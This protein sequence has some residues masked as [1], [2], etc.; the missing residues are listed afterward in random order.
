MVGG[1]FS[2]NSA[3]NITVLNN[4]GTQDISFNASP[5]FSGSIGGG[6]YVVKV[7]PDGKILMGG[8]FD[9]YNDNYSLGT[10]GRLLGTDYYT[11]RGNAK[12]DS[13][14]NGCGVSDI[15]YPFLQLKAVNSSTTSSFFS[16]SDGAYVCLLKNGSNVITPLLDNPSYFSV[17]P[18]SVTINYPQTVSPY[19]QDFCLTPTGNHPDVSIKVLPLRAA[20]PGFDAKYKLIYKN[21]GNQITNGTVTLIFNDAVADLVSANPPVSSQS[22]GTLSWNY[23]NLLPFQEREI[24]LTLQLNSPTQTPPLNT[25]DVLNFTATVSLEQ[26]DETPLDNTFTLNQT[27]ANSQD[28]NNKT[29]LQGNTIT[30]EA[31]G[32]YVDY[33]I[34]FENLG[35]YAAQMFRLK[36]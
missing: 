20:R 31:A 34:R 10:Y 16:Y 2:S 24:L 25:G 18:S 32:Q 27:L 13:D 23:T 12:V 7:Q 29:C 35:N 6:V 36:T 30:P 22:F 15:G 5:G 3:Y 26:T 33:T 11:L 14:N 4:D 17:S 8:Y 9:K 28:P 21:N 1:G 19:N